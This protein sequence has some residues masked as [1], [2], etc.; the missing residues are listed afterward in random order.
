MKQKTDSKK[1]S[2]K[3]EKLLESLGKIDP[4]DKDE[5]VKALVGGGERK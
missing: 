3:V 2:I 1:Q 5:L 4:G